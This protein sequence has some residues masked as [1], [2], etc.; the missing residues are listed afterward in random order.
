MH[1]AESRIFFFFFRCGSIHAVRSGTVEARK[2]RGSGSGSGD[3]RTLNDMNDLHGDVAEFLPR[4]MEREFHNTAKRHFRES[5]LRIFHVPD[6]CRHC[7]ESDL[8]IFHVPDF[9]RYCLESDLRVFHVPDICRYCLESGLRIF[10]VPDF[11]R[12]RCL[13]RTVAQPQIWIHARHGL[14]A[15]CCGKNR[16]VF[17]AVKIEKRIHMSGWKLVFAAIL[18]SNFSLKDMAPNFSKLA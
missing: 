18:F 10:H 11:C 3:Y 14:A 16:A 7:L 5:G 17:L 4:S 2:W 1:T 6:F 9:F 12:H 8:R 13:F 15:F